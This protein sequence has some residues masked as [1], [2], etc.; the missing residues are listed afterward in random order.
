MTE[1]R[2]SVWRLQHVVLIA[3]M[4]AA[5]VACTSTPPPTAPAGSASPRALPSTVT[6]T[7]LASLSPSL[8]APTQRPTQSPT[9]ASISPTQSP[10]STGLT[11]DR[12][13]VERHL[14]ALQAIADANGGIRAAGTSGYDASV[15]YVAA[16]LSVLGYVPERPSID[17][18]TF[19]EAAPVTL[20]VGDQSWSGGEWLHAMRYS[21]GGTVS[22]LAQ[23][24]GGSGD[25][26]GCDQEAWEGFV[27]GRIAVVPPSRFP[28][29]RR[30]QV[31]LAQDHG[32]AAFIGVY[33]T[34]LANQI[35]RP[36][37]FDPGGLSIPVVAAGVEPANA[38]L[39]STTTGADVQL[40]VQVT[41]GS[42]TLQ[43]VIAEI[44]GTS[45][46]VIMLGGH[47]DS[48]LDGPGVNDNGSGVAALLA[49]ADSV[50]EQPQPALTIRFAFWAAEEFGEFGSTAYVDG[51]STADRARI[52]AYIN[53]DMVGSVGG[54]RQVYDDQLAPAGSAEITQL[55]T[56]ALVA[57]GTPGTP[58]D[59]GGA[60]DHAQF[61]R[62]GIPTGG[63]FSGLDACYH[64]A[65][66][67]RANIDMT[68]LLS[69][70]SA[71]ASTLEALAF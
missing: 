36:T 11:V 14:D 12:A 10:P 71:T 65:C 6:T 3:G 32:A 54:T 22:G 62:V 24:V 8:P 30:Q 5:L 50:A 31:V 46:D 2:R 13:D 28:C 7:A 16:E 26:G 55:L 56:D 64:L 48:V 15:E 57:A 1:A 66:D 19:D 53:L 27:A 21:P 4:C 43:S 34:W 42:A 61:Q 20:S 58:T 68:M 33:P 70:A 23:S 18:T 59:L 49:L 67:T 44:P 9:T 40:D 60:S 45:T 47:L 63:L 52:K 38:L 25:I 37:L 69:L 51:L 39:Q 41:T 35:R 17:F 29:P